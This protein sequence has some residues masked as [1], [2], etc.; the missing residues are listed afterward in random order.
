MLARALETC[1]AIWCGIHNSRRAIWS[2]VWGGRFVLW[3]CDTRSNLFCPSC[4]TNICFIAGFV[5]RRL[6]PSEISF[7][8]IGGQYEWLSFSEKQKQRRKHDYTFVI[9]FRTEQ[10]SLDINLPRHTVTAWG[11]LT[12]PRIVIVTLKI[13]FLV[14]CNEPSRVNFQCLVLSLFLCCSW[15]K[16]ND[17]YFAMFLFSHLPETIKQK[18]FFSS[19]LGEDWWFF[20]NLESCTCPEPDFPPHGQQARA[21]QRQQNSTRS[22]R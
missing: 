9:L 11:L 13:F 19:H 17:E 18:T 7:N 5:G 12:L 1:I 4:H 6:C 10:I 20:L 21:A 22:V 15:I 16:D 2:K 8:R 14:C 3:V